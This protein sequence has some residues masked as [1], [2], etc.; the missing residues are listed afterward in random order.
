MLNE[1]DQLDCK[2]SWFDNV[3]RVADGGILIVDTGSDDGTKE[4]FEEKMKEYKDKIVFLTDDIILRRGYGPARNHLRQTSIQFFPHAHWC[5]YLDADER[6]DP[7]DFHTFKFLKDYLAVNYDVIAFPRLNRLNKHTN[8][9]KV[10]YHVHPDYQS[11]MTRLQSKLRYI[12]K[13][14]KQI[15]DFSGVYAQLT[16]PKIHHFHRST[17]PV[18]RD[19]IGKVCAKLHMEDDEY[20]HTY[21]EHHKEAHYRELLEKEG[22]K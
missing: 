8:E 20:G 11:R 4:F 14:H 9:T 2:G 22:L 13:L 6:I 3:K 16:N 18:K 7:R 15:I 21:P 10:D 19:Y 12:R 1:I 17:D 5:C